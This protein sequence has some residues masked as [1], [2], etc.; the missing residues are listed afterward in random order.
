MAMRSHLHQRG[1]G[2]PEVE[3]EEP[4]PESKGFSRPR[5]ITHSR[6][7]V[8]LTVEEGIFRGDQVRLFTGDSER[9]QSRI[10][11]TSVCVH[12]GIHTTRHSEPLCLSPTNR[13]AGIPRSLAGTGVVRLA[14]WAL[15][16]KDPGFSAGLSSRSPG[17]R[18]WPIGSPRELNLISD[19]G[20]LIRFPPP[21][22]TTKLAPPDARGER[23]PRG[24][25][26]LETQKLASWMQL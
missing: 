7:V 6:A 22:H 25:P 9:N 2:Q 15:S 3:L 20:R 18:P 11:T 14:A 4:G 17:V 13:Q 10:A 12:R 19:I 21:S 5:H 26:S 1:P 24:F 16:D 8:W 23:G